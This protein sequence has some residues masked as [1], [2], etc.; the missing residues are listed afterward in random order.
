MA[1]TVNDTVRRPPVSGVP[2]SDARVLIE[3]AGVD[4]ERVNGFDIDTSEAIQGAY[5]PEVNRNGRWSVVLTPN[6]RILPSGTVWRIAERVDDIVS[7]SFIAAPDDDGD[8]EV[9]ELLTDPPGTIESTALAAEILRAMAAEDALQD[10]ID[11]IDAED[12]QGQ[13]DD[14]VAARTAAD[15]ALAA[16]L[17]FRHDQGIPASVWIITHNLGYRPAGVYVED[18]GGTPNEPAIAHI[19]IT[20]VELTFIG[21]MGGFALL[22]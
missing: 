2:A 1:P 11:V 18:S 3:L 15:A 7:V 13:I 4:G 21:A 14:E 10:Q 19:D 16:R 22:S 20:T 8:Y 6:V 17:S 9:V 5:S 12:L